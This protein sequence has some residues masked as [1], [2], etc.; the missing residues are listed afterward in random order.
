MTDKIPGDAYVIVIGAMKCG[1]T[2]LYNYLV[3]HPAIC[4]SIDKEP[5][6]FSEHQRHGVQVAAYED[7]WAFDAGVHKYTLE[8]STGYT[9]YPAE[10][11]VARRIYEYGIRPR[12]IYIIRDPFQRIVSH[13]NYKRNDARWDLSITDPHLI[14]TSNYYLQ[15]EQYRKYFERSDILLL[16]FGELVENPEGLLRRT[17]DFL[18]LPHSHFPA[19]FEAVNATPTEARSE[20]ERSVR[21]SGL[22]RIFPYLPRPLKRFG[23]RLVPTVPLPPKR[24]LTG[25]ERAT[26]HAALKDDMLRLQQE[27]GFDVGRW[28]FVA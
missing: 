25:D 16:D 27:Y 4:P 28:G 13:Y 8:A 26:I 10:P 19:E 1:T 22:R 3:C 20:F 24:K 9:K 5:E 18:R 17:Y 12:F 14:N 11:D 2:S 15:L 21:R 23:R 6:F 7:L